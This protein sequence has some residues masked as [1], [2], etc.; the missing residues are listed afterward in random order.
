MQR[1]RWAFFSG[2]QEVSAIMSVPLKEIPGVPPVPDVDVLM[3]QVRAGVADKIGRG[4]YTPADLEELRRVERETRERIDFGPAPADDIAR[5]TSTWDPL[6]P[7]VFTSHRNGVG[8]IIVAAK[9]WLRRLARPVMAVALVRQSEFNHA[10]AR[11][12]TGASRGVRSLEAGNDA[13]LRRIDELERRTLE[14]HAR[15]DQLQA[16]V[17][18]LQARLN[19]GGSS[20]VK[21]E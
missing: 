7:H 3:Q 4:I 6:G 1:S 18:G 19:A 15:C 21:P 2:L 8:I 20:A 11:L 16:E 12:L 17:H 13:Q 10:V 14:L 5:L 9:R